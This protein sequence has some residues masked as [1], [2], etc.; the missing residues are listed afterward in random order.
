MHFR[1]RT[2][3]DRIDLDH[4]RYRLVYNEGVKFLV[5]F[6][7]LPSEELKY[8]DAFG[9]LQALLEWSDAWEG[10]AP[11]CELWLWTTGVRFKIARGQLEAISN[12]STSEKRKEGTS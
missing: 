8:R 7:G 2:E 10:A 1:G 12:T 9:M 6:Q 5:E 11:G 4:W 3:T